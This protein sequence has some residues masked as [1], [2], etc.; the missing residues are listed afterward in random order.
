MPVTVEYSLT[1]LG[2]TLAQTVDMVRLW[3]ETQIGAVEA[4]QHRYDRGEPA[5]PDAVSEPPR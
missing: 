5:M 4:A 3:A 2:R 1:D